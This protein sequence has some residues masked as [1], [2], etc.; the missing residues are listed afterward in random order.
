[1][2]IGWNA[3]IVTSLQFLFPIPHSPL[4][5]TSCTLIAMGLMYR[6]DHL[7]TQTYIEA[8]KHE[9]N[10]LR[11][12]NQSLWQNLGLR[13]TVMHSKSQATTCALVGALMVL[14]SIAGASLIA[15]DAHAHAVSHTNESLTSER[16]IDRLFEENATTLQQPVRRE[17]QLESAN[18]VL[19]AATVRYDALVTCVP[20]SLNGVVFVAWRDGHEAQV[21]VNAVSPGQRARVLRRV[22]RCVSSVAAHQVLPT[23]TT[24]LSSER[25]IQW[26]MLSVTPTAHHRRHRHH[27]Q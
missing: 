16:S 15:E 17:I 5:A 24:M 1:M 7:A 22:S 14:A 10:A 12:V 26:V 8:L 4:H 20:P 9:N 19:P 27:S 25:T 6:D 18:P 21:R 23:E 3:R 13:N 2:G 11:S